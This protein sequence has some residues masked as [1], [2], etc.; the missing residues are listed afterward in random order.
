MNPKPSIPS[1]RRTSVDD[2]S[3]TLLPPL[4]EDDEDEVVNGPASDI[5]PFV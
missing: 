1:P 3:G 2:D 4:D 5:T